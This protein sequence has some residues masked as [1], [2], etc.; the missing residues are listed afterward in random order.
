MSYD[1]VC[2][3]NQF[4][5]LCSL[6]FIHNLDITHNGYPMDGVLVMGVASF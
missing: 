4:L 6:R 1:F 3:K 5:L 2:G